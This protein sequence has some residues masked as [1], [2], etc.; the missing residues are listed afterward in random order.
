[1]FH[2]L[3]GGDIFFGFGQYGDT[4]RAHRRLFHQALEGAAAKRFQPQTL[5]HAHD[6]IRRLLEEPETFAGHFDQ[7]EPG[8]T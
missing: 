5:K 1:M 3:I 4:W 8:H 7:F 6:L 2:D